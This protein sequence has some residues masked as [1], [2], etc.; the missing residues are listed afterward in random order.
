MKICE[1]IHRN[2]K[3]TS[4]LRKESRNIPSHAV[5]G[6]S[7]LDE[8]DE[9]LWIDGEHVNNLRFADIT[10]SELHKGKRENIYSSLS[11]KCS[12]PQATSPH[13]GT[14]R[15]LPLFLQYIVR[16]I[17]NSNTRT[18]LTPHSCTPQAP[19]GRTEGS[20]SVLTCGQAAISTTR[21][22]AL[23]GADPADEELH[24]PKKTGKV[25]KSANWIT[26]SVVPNSVTED[27]NFI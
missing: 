8:D 9:G 4:R 25:Y 23:E 13:R 10:A 17:N 27:M 2:S 15:T 22:E 7:I 11:L 21:H 12:E 5:L 14:S 16:Y 24:Y 6:G 20:V 26:S 3:T 1:D 18:Q 19:H